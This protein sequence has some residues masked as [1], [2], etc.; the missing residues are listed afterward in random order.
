MGIIAAM[1]Y[2]ALIVD[3]LIIALGTYGAIV[4]VGDFVQLD[5]FPTP[6]QFF[7]I[8]ARRWKATLA[9]LIANVLFFLRLYFGLF[10]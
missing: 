1:S 9:L 3:L 10:R 5:R 4:L 2:F 6:M 8:L 7:E